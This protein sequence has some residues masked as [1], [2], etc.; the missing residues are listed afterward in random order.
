MLLAPSILTADFARLGQQCQQAVD[1]GTDWLQ[2]D[3]MDGTF[4]PNISIGLPVVTSLRSVVSVP[5]DCHLMVADPER[6]ID[7]F[8]DAGANNITIHVEATRHVH[9]AV[10]QIKERGLTAG[11]A[12][13]PG[14]PLSALDELLPDLD[15]VLLMTV[16]PG[17]GGQAYIATMT[18]KIRRMRAILDERGM[19]HVH[20]QVDG[21]IKA[22]NIRMVAEAGATNIVVGS[23]VYN[24]Q[25]SVAAAI[26]GLRAALAE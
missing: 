11:V 9:R 14:T 4:V 7:A 6:Y 2:I 23:G 24:R 20:V 16:N 10:Q 25:Q 22:S 26:D 1:A 13:N 8:A 12:L 5:L 3:V 18:D 17:F 21:G 19:H 15:L